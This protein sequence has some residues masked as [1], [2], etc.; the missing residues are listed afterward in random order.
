MTFRQLIAALGRRLWIVLAVMIIAAVVAV[1]Y[2]QR[3]DP[4]YESSTT[5]RMSPMMTQAILTGQLGG[6]G[7]DIDPSLITSDVILGPAET[8]LGEPAGS[9]NGAV[10]FGVLESVS[11]NSLIIT[12]TGSTSEEAQARAAAVQESYAT[13]LQGVLESTK[14]TLQ[15]RLAAATAQA[16]GFQQQVAADPD[17]SIAANNLATSLASMS[18][19]TAQISDLENAGAPLTIT[20]AAPPGEST[21]PAPW[22][23]AGVALLCGLLA[24]AGLALL[25]EHFD[26]RIRDEE[27]I[28]PLT[29]VPLLGV[30]ANDRAV[31]RKRQR[32]PAAVSERT[33][34]S[35][36]I[37]SLRTSAQVMLPGGNGVLVITSVEPGDGKTFV[38]ANLAL[39]W[40]RA[41]RRVIVVGGDM[42]RPELGSYFESATDGSGLGGLLLDS[43][44]GKRPP[45]QAQIAEALRPTPYRGLRVLPAGSDISEPA[46]LLASAGLPRIIRYLA[47]LADIVVIDTPP[48]LALADASELA[49]H[50]D[51]VLVIATVGRTRRRMLADAVDSLRSNGAPLYGVVL[52]R[53]KRKLPK[54]YAAYYVNSRQT[55]RA[56]KPSVAVQAGFAAV[57]STGAAVAVPAIDA[58]AREDSLDGMFDPTLD[59]EFD[60]TDGSG[61][62]DSLDEEFGL[63]AEP[64]F[65]GPADD[66]SVEFSHAADSGRLRRDHNASGHAD[67]NDDV[68]AHSDGPD[69]GESH[70]EPGDPDEAEAAWR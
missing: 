28:E 2:V 19:L 37:R 63:T 18:A 1:F 46:D 21:N 61:Y 54:S 53:V 40:A 4:N 8:G 42:R 31:A 69:S 24:G 52:N 6:I 57:A 17:D 67:G 51:G 25:R 33:A 35:E 13:Y 39:S 34:L 11:T 48:A 70:D 41:G 49:A 15:D 50:A 29:Q 20:S 27:E 5:V 7:V 44:D 64:E 12:A 59:D 58:S 23:V 60:N 56:R 9:L 55:G 26:T 38:S 30:L 16:T 36:G 43:A 68:D 22:M 47:K 10:Q 62:D 14:T 32:L 66:G 65:D 45:N 3:Q